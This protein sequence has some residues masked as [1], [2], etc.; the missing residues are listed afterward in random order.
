MWNIPNYVSFQHILAGYLTRL[1]R[2]K[3][4]K[5]PSLIVWD[6]DVEGIW[7]CVFSSK[8]IQ[9]TST[10]KNSSLSDPKVYISNCDSYALLVALKQK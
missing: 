8:Q 10:F 4:V 3:A 9:D 1:Q 6:P 7:K 5:L 2:F